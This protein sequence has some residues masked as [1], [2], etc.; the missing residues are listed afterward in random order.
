MSY[1]T[2]N[3]P[4][5]NPILPARPSYQPTPGPS[6]QP[7]QARPQS[8]PQ[9][10]PPPQPYYPPQIPYYPYLSPSIS[11]G[12]PYRPHPGYPYYPA[13]TF[14]QS[15][16]VPYPIATP[17]GYSYSPTY[18]QQPQQVTAPP[19][20]KRRF[21]A[22]ASSTGG[23]LKAWRNCSY[24]RCKFVGP[25]EEVEVHEGDR[26]LIF[27]KAKFLQLSEEEEKLAKQKG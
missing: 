18:L 9:Q 11:G 22:P 27:P 24:P 7:Y 25:G 1:P 14:G 21:D 15:L 6:R 16:F 10:R 3:S 17:E 23:G 5:R 2:C 4:G 13:Q 8:R 19:A 12:Y 26:H 20:K